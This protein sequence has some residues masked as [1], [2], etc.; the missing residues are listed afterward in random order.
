MMLSLCFIL[1]IIFNI[2]IANATIYTMPRR[3]TSTTTSNNNNNNIHSNTFNKNPKQQQSRIDMKAIL[4]ID[5]YKADSQTELEFQFFG[6]PFINGPYGLATTFVASNGEMDLHAIY[7]NTYGCKPYKNIEQ[8]M[9]TSKK[10]FGLFIKRGECAFLTKMEHAVRAG[11]SA[12]FIMNQPESLYVNDGKNNS[13]VLKDMCDIFAH[14]EPGNA[15]KLACDSDVGSCED[16]TCSSGICLPFRGKSHMPLQQCCLDDK[17]MPMYID[18]LPNVTN[19]IP[20]IFVNVGDSHNLNIL[21]FNSSTTSNNNNN[22]AADV[23]QLDG[24]SSI[25]K[26]NNHHYTPYTLTIKLRTAR[27]FDFGILLVGIFAVF[28]I[29]IAT[30]GSAKVERMFSNLKYGNRRNNANNNNGQGA[31]DSNKNDNA[32]R[33]AQILLA[34][35]DNSEVQTLSVK[36]VLVFVCISAFSLSGIYILIKLGVNI[37]TIFNIWFIMVTTS[38]IDNLLI[39]P[40]LKPYYTPEGKMCSNLRTYIVDTKYIQISKITIV[41]TCLSAIIPVWWYIEMFSNST[42]TWV[43]Q[44]ILGAFICCY[45]AMILRIPNLKVGTI[46]LTAF[47][48]YDVFMVFLTPFIFGGESIMMEVATAGGRN[49]PTTEQ[50]NTSVIPSGGGSGPTDLTSCARNPGERLPLLM[51][52]PHFNEWPVGYSMLGL[53]DIMI[54]SFFLSLALRFDYRFGNNPCCAGNGRRRSQSSSSSSS[55][56]NDD[57]FDTTNNGNV[58]FFRPTYW[59]VCIFF[60]AVAL[61]LANLANLYELTIAG[62]KGQPALMWIDPLLIIPTI[63]IAKSRGQFHEFWYGTSEDSNDGRNNNDNND[64]SQVGMEDE[65]SLLN[66]ANNM[67]DDEAGMMVEMIDD[68]GGKI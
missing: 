4:E 60:Y 22:A 40:I 15:E 20:T 63:L 32:R 62:V 38:S 33:I 35:S 47:L 8:Q 21:F 55:T 27:K 59:A 34:R 26:Q 67:D 68:G 13:R 46:C 24:D 17:L 31:N 64:Y 3:A 12:L 56:S 1:F 66:S 28:T 43:L 45:I 36:E 5:I 54:P 48:M 41:R 52:V 53:G 65:E 7:L 44:N 10:P 51:Q 39:N 61:C 14:V 29:T 23:P 50:T 2:N 42:F 58:S 30:Y 49:R 19:H 37:I 57:H 16:G 11:A 25:N 18:K 9:L 6:S